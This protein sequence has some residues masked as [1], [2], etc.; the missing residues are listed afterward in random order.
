M[1]QHSIGRALRSL[2]AQS[3]VNWEAIIIDDASSDKTMVVAQEWNA[4]DARFRVARL[5]ENRGSAAAR[6]AGLRMARGEFVAYLDDD[7]EFYPDYLQRVAALC[8][9]TDVLVFGF[10]MLYEDGPRGDRP[11][12]WDP[13]VVG[14]DLFSFNPGVPLGI[15]HR[16]SLVERA[17]HFN[18][19]VWM[20]DDFDYWRRLARV[21]AKFTYVSAKSGIY[22]IRP[23]TVSRIPRLAPPQARPFWRTGGR[24]CRSS[25]PSA[26]AS[27]RASRRGREGERYARSPSFRRIVC[28]TPAATRP[29]PRLPGYNCLRTTDLNVR[30]FAGRISIPRKRS[31]WSRYWRSAVIAIGSAMRRVGPHRARMIFTAVRQGRHYA[32]QH[33]LNARPLARRGRSRRF[34]YRLRHLPEKAA[35]G[36]G[37]GLWRRPGFLRDAAAGDAIGHPDRAFGGRRGLRR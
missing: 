20:Q 13:T 31:W 18:E 7:D 22:H 35:A 36:R 34:P 33:L 28:S 24:A 37:L 9:K 3:L 8:N 12:S 27:I 5:S 32:V 17:G 29:P 10:D 11:E 1:A 4:R 25:R 14:R 16:R 2:L 19:M 15:S 30:L 6:N 26:T 21:G 23:G